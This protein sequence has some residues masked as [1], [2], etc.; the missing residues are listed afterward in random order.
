MLSGKA[1]VTVLFDA[2]QVIQLH[3]L[4]WCT[5]RSVG[6]ASEGM[7]DL[8]QLSLKIL[9]FNMVYIHSTCAQALQHQGLIAEHGCV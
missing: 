5:Y 1:D 8:P 7:F 4:A 2:N 3:L 9:F 6:N